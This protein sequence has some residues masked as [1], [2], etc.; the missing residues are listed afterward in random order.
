[1]M[2]CLDIVRSIIYNRNNMQHDMS[3]DETFTL[4]SCIFCMEAIC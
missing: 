4:S 1:M 3:D 2:V